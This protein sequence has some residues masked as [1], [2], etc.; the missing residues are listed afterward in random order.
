[1]G[2]ELSL[3]VDCRSM[4]VVVVFLVFDVGCWLL[5]V[6]CRSLFVVVAYVWF[7]VAW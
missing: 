6:V 2:C 4:C 7:V 1:M 5:V 3:F